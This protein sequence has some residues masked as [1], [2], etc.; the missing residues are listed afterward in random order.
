MKDLFF[1]MPFNDEQVRIIQLLETSNGV[2]VQ[3]PPGT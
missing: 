2:V 3:G 1:P